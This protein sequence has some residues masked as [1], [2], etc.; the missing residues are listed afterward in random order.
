MIQAKRSRFLHDT[1]K[2]ENI[3]LSRWIAHAEQ[4]VKELTD[5]LQRRQVAIMPAITVC[6]EFTDSSTQTKRNDRTAPCFAM[7]CQVQLTSPALTL[8]EG[9][10]FLAAGEMNG[11]VSLW[12]IGDTYR[13]ASSSG[14]YRF[15][16]E[17]EFLPNQQTPITKGMDPFTGHKASV[18]SLAWLEGTNLTSVSLDGTLKLW[19]TDNGECVSTFDVGMAAV[20]HAS[21][22]ASLLVAGCVRQLANVDLRDPSPTVIKTDSAITALEA[23]NLGLVLGTST[24]EVLLFDTRVMRAYQRLQISPAHLP[25]SRISGV[26]ATTVTCFDG[27]VR[28]LGTE[29]PLFVQRE[30]EKASINGELIGSCTVPIVEKDEFI[31]SGSTNGKAMVWTSTGNVFPLAHAKGATVYDCVRL[32]MYVGS[33]VTCD[34][35]RNITMWARAFDQ[36]PSPSPTMSGFV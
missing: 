16:A 31:V 24:G 8:S 1:L 35:A 32:S 18:T 13:S 5:S 29:L 2:D 3:R 7:A 36:S 10:Q 21:T 22:D 12:S 23:T 30:C 15:S 11:N 17:G 33:F 34:S 27:Y 25:V 6:N 26:E 28:L 14:L 20:S 9:T 19:S 4:K